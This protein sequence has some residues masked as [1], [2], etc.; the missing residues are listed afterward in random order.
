MEDPP[1]KGRRPD[2]KLKVMDKTNSKTNDI[3]AAWLNANGSISI[4]L[5]V[6][7]FMQYNPDLLITLFPNEELSK[8]YSKNTIAPAVT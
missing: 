2:Y 3:G 1:A 7:T 4:Q 5:N 6:C 8:H